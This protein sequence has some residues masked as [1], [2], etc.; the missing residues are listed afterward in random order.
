MAV[1]RGRYAL[2][3]TGLLTEWQAYLDEQLKKHA[4]KYSL[5]PLLKAL[6]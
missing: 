6:R 4:R 5:M 3:A 1:L 2:E